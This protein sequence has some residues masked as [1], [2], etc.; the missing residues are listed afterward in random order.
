MTEI[1][2]GKAVGRE[3]LAER[4]TAVCK[5]RNEQALRKEE[6]FR[7]SNA[8]DNAKKAR[9][10]SCVACELVCFAFLYGEA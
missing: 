3:Y 1:G 2:A 10:G 7:L 5:K 9:H 4:P 6:P 8:R